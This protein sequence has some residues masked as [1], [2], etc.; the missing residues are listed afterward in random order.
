M[1]REEWAWSESE[2]TVSS[3]ATARAARRAK[4]SGRGVLLSQRPAQ[5]NAHQM[6]SHLD[7][8]S[9]SGGESIVLFLGSQGD[10]P[11]LGYAFKHVELD[12]RDRNM[13]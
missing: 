7:P 4:L 11:D 9:S 8:D 10:N 1:G 3:P 2:F 6:L 5:K 13:R 12:P